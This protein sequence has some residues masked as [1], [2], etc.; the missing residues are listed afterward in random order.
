[1]FDLYF[2]CVFI[3]FSSIGLI[4]LCG[5]IRTKF[6]K[7]RDP[8]VLVVAI[9]SLVGLLNIALGRN[10]F[11]V[12]PH[13]LAHCPTNRRKRPGGFVE[14][15]AGRFLLNDQSSFSQ[16]DCCQD[17]R[18]NYPF[19]IPGEMLKTY[20][21]KNGVIYYSSW[22]R[23]L[24]RAIRSTKSMERPTLMAQP[25]FLA[26]R[27]VTTIINAQLLSHVLETGR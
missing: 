5:F 12:D 23:V 1:M 16:W 4:S 6:A 15:H 20:V 9:V 14:P 10:A 21:L 17:R 24:L 18:K 3:P 19:E 26:G 11:V 7:A 13:R 22:I 2:R 8:R 25:R 27:A